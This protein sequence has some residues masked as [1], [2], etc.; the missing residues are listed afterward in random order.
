MTL[1][2]TAP[3]KGLRS[4]GKLFVA[5]G[6]K[7]LSWP[8][9]LVTQ[10]QVS[11]FMELML[12]IRAA[13]LWLGFPVSDDI[14]SSG[15]DN[16]AAY[17]PP[18]I[19]GVSIGERGAVVD[20]VRE[21]GRNLRWVLASI[22]GLVLAGIGFALTANGPHANLL[23]IAFITPGSLILGYALVTW[24]ATYFQSEVI[25]VLAKAETSRGGWS[26][27]PPNS[28]VTV[29]I[30]GG[31]ARSENGPY[32]RI[33]RAVAQD[34]QLDSALKAILERLESAARNPTEPRLA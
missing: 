22:L 30:S 11:D 21:R 19:L 9:G 12:D 3:R 10:I 20:R 18:G 31:R 13:L 27:P 15:S 7:R 28:R 4:P 33:L 1:P 6:R 34:P 24:M 5:V 32:G 8:A 16:R 23:T 14:P 29:E 2:S 25:Q 26:L 17:L